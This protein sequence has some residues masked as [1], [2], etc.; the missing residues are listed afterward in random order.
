LS[1]DGSAGGIVAAA[2]GKAAPGGITARVVFNAAVCCVATA[3]C[4]I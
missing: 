4:W 2:A 1:I 3:A